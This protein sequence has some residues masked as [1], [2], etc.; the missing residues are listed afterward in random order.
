MNSKELLEQADQRIAEAESIKLAKQNIVD[1]ERLLNIS[2][3]ESYELRYCGEYDLPLEQSLDVDDYKD[4]MGI[5]RGA[6]RVYLSMR[7]VK[8]EQLLGI[9]PVPEI[10]PM[11]KSVML[12]MGDKPLFQRMITPDS[13]E[14]IIPEIEPVDV[15]KA[16]VSEA[17]HI[18]DPVD[19]KLAGILQEE[20][21]KIEYKSVEN[22]GSLGKYP[23][24]KKQPR[25]S[26]NLFEEIKKMYVDE[27]KTNKEIA[28]VYKVK[29]SDVS[30]F[31]AKHKLNRR[32]YDK[33]I[34][35]KPNPL[36]QPDETEHP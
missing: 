35:G 3:N 17:L 24:N 21:Q 23:P 18:I 4:L 14:V 19:D 2:E 31:V 34:G 15:M 6:F 1:L 7:K 29:P 11:P 28:E 5:V 26:D 9:Q 36:K 10:P 16:A 27:G 30:N 32:S 8:L 12:T 22:E 20:A 33:S 13:P 25:L